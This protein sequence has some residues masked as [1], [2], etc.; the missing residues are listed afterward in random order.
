MP[1]RYFLDTNIFVYTFDDREPKKKARA[2]ELV[3]DALSHRRGIISFQVVQEFL[4]VA[5]RKFAQPLSS[6][7][8]RVYLDRVL[9]PLCEVLPTLDLYRS[10]LGLAERWKFSFYDSVI[11]AAAIQG[12]CEILYSEDLQHRQSVEGVSVVNPFVSST[13]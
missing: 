8:A 3:S 2:Q 12:E 4:N 1:D 11:I 10:A 7:D 13:A 6:S 5:T 9:G